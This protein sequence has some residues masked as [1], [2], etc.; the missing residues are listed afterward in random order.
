MITLAQVLAGLVIIGL[1]GSG[2]EK[3]GQNLK[4]PR[5]EATGKVLEAI[6]A[7]APKIIANI[8]T[9]FKGKP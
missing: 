7:D 4:Y 6:A 1:V 3:V 5:V 2:L 9:A 8:W